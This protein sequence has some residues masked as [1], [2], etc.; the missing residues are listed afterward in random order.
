MWRSAGGDWL[1]D[2]QVASFRGTAH[3]HE[4]SKVAVCQSSQSPTRARTTTEKVMPPRVRIGQGVSRLTSRS[5]NRGETHR[6][7]RSR[8]APRTA[9][10]ATRK[11]RCSFLSWQS[12]QQ[13]PAERSAPGRSVS[14]GL[15]KLCGPRRQKIKIRRGGENEPRHRGIA[16]YRARR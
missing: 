4:S 2:E 7:S 6:S 11:H 16:R 9:R 8:L 10:R 5:A 1:I 12:S 3:F 15:P 13:L 14:L